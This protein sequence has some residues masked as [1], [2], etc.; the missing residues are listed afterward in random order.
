MYPQLFVGLATVNADAAAGEATG[1]R[2]S[3]HQLNAAHRH[4]KW[5]SQRTGA[6]WGR[7]AMYS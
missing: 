3:F 7:G 2:S 5:R 6:G 4:C 1:E